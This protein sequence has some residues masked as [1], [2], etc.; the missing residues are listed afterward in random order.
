M[1][2]KEEVG[3]RG[4]NEAWSERVKT[5][6]GKRLMKKEAWTERGEEEQGEVKGQGKERFEKEEE[7]LMRRVKRE[8]WKGA[9]NKVKRTARCC[10]ELLK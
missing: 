2:E 4:E 6:G 7:T 3:T 5:G 10:G 9:G 8:A 1:E